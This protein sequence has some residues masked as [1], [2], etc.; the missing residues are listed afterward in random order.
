MTSIPDA[1]KRHAL[2]YLQVA[3]RAVLERDLSQ[4]EP[5]LANI[6]AAWTWA[7]SDKTN[8]EL[9]IAFGEVAWQLFEV[10]RVQLSEA[11]SELRI[12]GLPGVDRTVLQQLLQKLDEI[13]RAQTLIHATLG[14]SITA[15]GE[16]SVA[17]AVI[18]NSVVVTGDGVTIQAK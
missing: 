9:I 16:R 12:A 7:C 8:P 6:R 1:R 14:H 11:V 3:E 15:S 5:D 10:L 13:A 2:Y 4:L 17:G 18:V